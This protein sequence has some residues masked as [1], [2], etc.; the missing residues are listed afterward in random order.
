MLKKTQMSRTATLFCHIFN[1]VLETKSCPE[2]WPCGI[3]TPIY[4]S[5]G[6]DNPHNYRGI[7]INNC[8]S[9]LFNLV[10]TNRLTSFANE[11]GILKNNQI[12]FR[13]RFPHC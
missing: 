1:T 7:I 2:D 6:N 5:D 8:L 10:L 4:K 9:K 11:K 13:K 12:G 3:I